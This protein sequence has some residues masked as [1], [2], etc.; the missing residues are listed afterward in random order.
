MR[1]HAQFGTA[2]WLLDESVARALGME[3]AGA[4]YPPF[5][6][7]VSARTEFYEEPTALPTV[8]RS[9]IKL[10]LSRRDFTINTL[11]I[12]LSPG[13]FGELLDFYGGEQ[14]LHSGLI[15]VLHSLSFV[16]DP[17]RM[18]RAVR[19]E[20]RLGFRIEPRT[21][22]LIRNTISLLDRV[23]G[24]RIRHE[25]ALILAEIEPLRALARLDQ[26]GILQAIH[27]DL[28]IDEWVRAAF[29]AIRFA[30]QNPPWESLTSFD[31][32]MLTTFSL[33][34]SRLPESE[35]E[36]L[37]RRL[38]FSRVNLGHLHNARTAIALLPDLEQ[39]QLPSMI[40]QWLEPLDEVGWLAA[41]AAAP[42]A[43]A[44]D[45][46]ASFARAL[47][48]VRPSIDGYEL[49]EITGLKPGPIYGTLLD[50]LRR[51]WLDGEVTTQEQEKEL[52]L[53]L[54]E[55]PEEMVRSRDCIE[56]RK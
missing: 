17:T 23:S 11:A 47:R 54:I 21:E 4:R 3:S 14:D 15:R 30:R 7:L 43:Q 6:D 24:D 33:L 26:L 42:N 52:L 37:G 25:L 53:R 41:W 48:F 49:Q 51:A 28:R 35:L 31:N 12:R 36:Q 1:S 38:Q 34:T 27:P 16:D 2:K 29:Y 10:D 32:W 8:E 19:L 5:I 55:H 9:S 39:D 46:I 56:R 22:E 13:R 40:V 18:L 45:Q 50:C 44:R 20:Q